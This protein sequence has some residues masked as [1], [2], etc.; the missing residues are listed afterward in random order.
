M[1]KDINRLVIRSHVEMKNHVIAADASP[2]PQI[3]LQQ[4]EACLQRKRPACF[5]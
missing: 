2:F 3:A 5:D 1:L 4:Q